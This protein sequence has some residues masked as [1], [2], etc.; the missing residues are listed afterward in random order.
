MEKNE[1]LHHAWDFVEHTG[2]SIFLTGKAGTGKTTFLR[3]LCE[4]SPKR[5][6][7]VAPTGVAAINAGGMTIHSFFQLPLS[8]Y[9][10]TAAYKQRYDFSKEKRSI[11]RTLDLLVIDE[12]S[13]VRSDLLDAIDNVMR[14]FR[15]PLKPFGG[16]QLLMIGDLQQLTPVVMPEEE[17]LLRNYYDTPYFFGSHALQQIPYVTIQLHHVYRQQ[18]QEFID[19]LNHIR[20]GRP[21][22]EDLAKLNA[23]Y[24][25][26]PM[27]SP[28]TTASYIRLTTHNRLA[29]A[30][31]EDQLMKLR[32]PA[33][34]FEAHIEGNFPEFAYPTD[35]SLTLKC[36]AQ[37]M[38]VKNDPSADHRFYN[39]RIG[40]VTQISDNSI[41]VRCEGDDE[42]INV[43]PL[44]WENA[45]YEL[46][47]DSK[48]IVTSVQGTFAQYPLRLAWAITIHKSQGLTFEHAIIDANHSF[49][50]GQVYV[51]LSRCKSLQ[52]LLLASPINASNIFG[53]QRVAAYIAQEE[54]QA[55]QSI[56]ALPR[57]KEDYYGEQ[58][59]QLFDFSDLDRKYKALLRQLDEHFYTTYPRLCAAH[60]EAKMEFAKKVIEVSRKWSAQITQMPAPQLHEEA[61][62]DRVGRGAVYFLNTLTDLLGALLE[63]TNVETDNKV[64]RR[65]MTDVLADCRLAYDVKVGTLAAVA[66]EGFTLNGYLHQKQ[67]AVL[68]AMG[69]EP[70]KEKRQRKA[71]GTSTKTKTSGT[72]TKP[73]VEKAATTRPQPVSDIQNQA[74]FEALR[75][76]RWDKSKETNLPPYTIL[77]QKALHAI[78]NNLPTTPQELLA[79]PY[80]G[81][82]T[83]EKYGDEILEIVNGKA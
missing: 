64:V 31:N 41:S 62:L 69:T 1:Q 3:T 58:L 7:V 43:E 72:K 5:M 21:T 54:E 40:T 38:F 82:L 51:A 25:R 67:M 30:Y 35:V 74:L 29:D 36:G 33:H 10:P 37:V 61:F 11:I 68:N 13:M 2:I 22:A 48:E 18:D 24:I 15:D 28:E 14:R 6:V 66:K 55:R 83:V 75:N 78:V 39:G 81:K 76:W 34:H 63:R 23:R 77:Q 60:R 71:Q 57:L 26:N 46:N 32:Q 4:R 80:I 12:I 73:V 53:D 52:G 50:A 47:P 20:A 42:D 8:P 17:A 27:Q 16:V 44:T 56:E 9:I 70:K 59:R 65:R 79:L 49:A 45:K 19:I